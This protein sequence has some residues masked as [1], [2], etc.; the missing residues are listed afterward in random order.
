MKLKYLLMAVAG[1]GLFSS[2]ESDEPSV[3]V[4]EYHKPTTFVLNTPQFANGVYDLINAETVNLTF[5][6]P[7][8]G[9][10]AACDYTV[11][12]SSSDQFAEGTVGTVTTVFHTCDIQVDANEFAMA[13]CTAKG[14]MGQEDID[15]ALDAAA[16]GVIPVYVRIKSKLTNAVVTDSE[17]VSNS[18]ILNA[19]PYFALPPVE[20]PTEMY[21]NGGFCDMDW[22]NA[23]KMVPVYDNPDKFWCIRYVEAGAAFQFN[24]TAADNA[25][26]VKF[27]NCTS[28]TTVEG[29]TIAADADGNLSVDKSGWYIFV[30]SVTIDGRDYVN[31]LMIFPPDVYIYGTCTGLGDNG[32]TDMPEWKFTVPA[33]G[34]GEFVSPALA[35]AGELRICIHPLVD[36]EQYFG[37]WWKSEFIIIDNKI[38]YRGAGGDQTRV[39]VGAG[40]KVYLNFTTG[41]ARVE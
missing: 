40:Q 22:A 9:Y 10:A 4:A 24:S 31:N 25:N 17:I 7:D 39:N 32:W 41:A 33:D 21:M 1:L 6:Q 8:Y 13:I 29:L 15:A 37:D 23:G 35:A 14:W 20:Q 38:E 28:A 3:A 34:D 19:V 26:V 36:G 30:V 2:C 12:V 18:I 27:D 16:D 11:E 5:S